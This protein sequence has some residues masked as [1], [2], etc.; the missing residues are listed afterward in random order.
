MSTN[1]AEFGMRDRWCQ[2]T[3]LTAG[4]TLGRPATPVSLELEG[5]ERP[6]WAVREWDGDREQGYVVLGLGR[7]G[8]S[9][10]DLELVTDCRLADDFAVVEWTP[11]LVNKGDAA[12]EPTGPSLSQI[13][14]TGRGCRW[15]ST[16]NRSGQCWRNASA[17]AHISWG[18]STR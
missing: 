3:G 16:L 14:P 8:G 15:R 13:G 17:C 7:T 6:L 5:G 9:V 2:G 11:W 10:G 18:T 12:G 4:L 1:N